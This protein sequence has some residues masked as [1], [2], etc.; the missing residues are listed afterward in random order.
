MSRPVKTGLTR[1]F[2]PE[3]RRKVVRLVLLN[4]AHLDA[5]RTGDPSFYDDGC[6]AEL[7]A[8]MPEVYSALN[9]APWDDDD[10]LL[11]VALEQT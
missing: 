6:H 2:G 8:L 7:V 5:I 1:A 10:A 3:M 11:A 9:I 4:A